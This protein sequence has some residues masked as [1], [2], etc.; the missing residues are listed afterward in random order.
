MNYQGI[1]KTVENIEIFSNRYKW[2]KGVIG[3]VFKKYKYFILTGDQ[4]VLSNWVIAFFAKI[5]NKKVFIWMHG[6]KSRKKLHWRSK[7][8]VYPF[9][10]LSDVFLLYGDYSRNLMIQK[11]FNPAKMHCRAASAKVS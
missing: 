8:K 7:L 1:K 11:G 9:Y 5:L 3:L 4:N 6:I 2:Q 10:N